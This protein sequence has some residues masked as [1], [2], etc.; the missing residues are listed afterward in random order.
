MGWSRRLGPTDPGVRR[1]WDDGDGKMGSSGSRRRGGRSMM[2]GS[3]VGEG[4]GERLRGRG[5]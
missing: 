3:Y 4:R 1:D 5:G 2:Y